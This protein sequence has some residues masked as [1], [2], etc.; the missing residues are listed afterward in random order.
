MRIQVLKWNAAYIFDVFPTGPILRD[1][2][3]TSAMA[4]V[5][6]QSTENQSGSM[7]NQ[8]VRSLAIDMVASQVIFQLA[9]INQ[10]LHH[11]Q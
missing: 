5:H 10:R 7:C 3:L 4:S 2:F 1:P 11:K 9:S 8:I 6:T